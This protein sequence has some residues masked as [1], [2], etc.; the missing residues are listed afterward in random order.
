[1]CIAPKKASEGEV[2]TVKRKPV[3]IGSVLASLATSICCIGPLLAI[4]FGL[5]TFTAARLE[6]LR[7]Y[8]LGLTAL[9]IMAGFYLTYR[10][11]DQV[12]AKGMCAPSRRSKTLLWVIVAIVIAAAA[13]PY[14]SGAILQ[15]QTRSSKA[16]ARNSADTNEAT[17][18]IAVSGMTCGSC[19]AQI[20]S[21]LAKTRGVKSADVSYEKGQAVVRYDPKATSVEAIRSAIEA[22]GYRADE[23]RDGSKEADAQPATASPNTL[24]GLPVSKLKEEFNRA[25][26]KVRVVALLSPTCDACQRGRG[27]IAEMFDQ[28]RSEK[29]AGFVVWLPMKPKDSANTAWLESEKLKDERINVRGWDGD[30]KIGHLFAKP[31]KLSTTAWDVYLVYAAGVKWEGNQPPQPSYWMHQLQGQ[32]ADRMLCLNPAALS[33]QVQK[34]LEV[35]K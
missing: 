33:S 27:V 16:S 23:T 35:G 3:L 10:K 12:C 31:L 29:L 18:T 4:V 28:Q 7:P 26:G 14:Y 9:L 21:T 22:M 1:V 20:Q 5:G 6:I 15:A 32:G 25:D 30:R 8:L 34:Y 17:A 13:F 24:A 19:A 11:R 2:K